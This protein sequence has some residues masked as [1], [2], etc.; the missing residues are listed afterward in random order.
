MLQQPLYAV[1]AADDFTMV[2]PADVKSNQDP[3]FLA[4]LGEFVS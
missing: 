3:S 1:T 4:Q 2:D